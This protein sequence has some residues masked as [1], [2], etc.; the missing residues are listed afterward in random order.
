MA[1]KKNYQDAASPSEAPMTCVDYWP[2]PT[3]VYMSAR[4]WVLFERVMWSSPKLFTTR[5]K[6]Q[7][8]VDHCNE[9]T[10]GNPF[11]LEVL[12]LRA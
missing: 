6:A 12:E 3:K 9:G 4:R 7:A 10:L 5:E 8:D 11:A 2:A 1:K